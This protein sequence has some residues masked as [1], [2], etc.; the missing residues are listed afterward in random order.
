VQCRWQ[1][2]NLP[3]KIQEPALP[4]FHSITMAMQQ[5]LQGWQHPVNQTAVASLHVLC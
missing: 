5:V 4:I 1:W 2:H 3:H